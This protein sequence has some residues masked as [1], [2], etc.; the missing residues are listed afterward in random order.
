MDSVSTIDSEYGKQC[1]YTGILNA[2]L[3]KGILEAESLCPN[4]LIIT[5]CCII[6]DLPIAKERLAGQYKSWELGDFLVVACKFKRVNIIVYLL[7]NTRL[8]DNDRIG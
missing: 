1:V 5:E 3:F 2:L 4:H 6:L 7:E 8:N